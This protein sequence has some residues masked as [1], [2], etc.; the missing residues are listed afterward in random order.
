M[1][2]IHNVHARYYL[3]PGSAGRAADEWH[4][5]RR[6][7][8]VV[9]ERLPRALAGRWAR[10]PQERD[11]VYRIRQL[12]VSLWLEDDRREEQAIAAAWAELLARAVAAALRG[13]PSA[14][15]VRY[16]DRAHFVAA[17]LGDLLAGRAWSRWMYAEFKPLQGLRAGRIAA[18]LIAPHPELLLPIADRLHR[19]RQWETLLRRLEPDDLALIWEQGPGR[20]TLPLLVS[21]ASLPPLP[22]GVVLEQGEGTLARN[23]LRLY[24]ALGVQGWPPAQAAAAAEHLARVHT[25]WQRQPAPWLWAALVKG[26]VHDAAAI[27]ALLVKLEDDAPLRE[28]LAQLLPREDGRR[29]L[30]KLVRTLELAPAAPANRPRQFTSSY[31]GLALLLPVLREL[32][33]HGQVGAAGLYQILLQAAGPAALPPP[34]TDSAVAWMAGLS[35]REAEAARQEALAWPDAGPQLAAKAAALSLHPATLLVLRRFAAGLRGF[36]TSSPTYLA[37]QFFNQPGHLLVSEEA[38]DV[39]LARSP[40]GIV[41]QMAGRTGEQGPIPWLGER[42]LTIMLP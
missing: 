34:W 21:P 28:W 4:T 26:E 14:N 31:A 7:D 2:R 25:F 5:Q 3:Q 27:A 1:L 11:A 17:F 39:H 23:R 33:L 22:P 13:G 12:H 6:L 32:A 36:A 10:S 16:D 35:P 37:G 9:R 18:L 30:A 20:T 8:R 19:Q 38:I 15:V 29:Y 40:L 24:V 42:R 41:L